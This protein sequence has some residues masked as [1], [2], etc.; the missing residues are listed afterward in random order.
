M[1]VIQKT[2]GIANISYLMQLA[3]EMLVEKQICFTE[4]VF[5]A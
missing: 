4:T 5:S 1:F 3:V 2:T